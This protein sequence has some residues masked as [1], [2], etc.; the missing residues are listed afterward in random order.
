MSTRKF[1]P[2]SCTQ[3]LRGLVGTQ[4]SIEAVAAR[5]LWWKRHAKDFVKCWEHEFRRSD[6]TMRLNLIYVANDILQKSRE[7]GRFYVEEFFK[8]LPQA[9][10]HMMKHSDEAVQK[11]LKRLVNVWSDRKVFG[12]TAMKTFRTIVGDKAD[13]P[14]DAMPQQGLLQP[15]VDAAAARADVVKALTAA[16]AAK[17]SA[18]ESNQAAAPQIA[19]ALEQV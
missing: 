10:Q 4:A 19:T 17:A 2:A 8:Y 16:D 7:A 12:A 9:L 1:D 5:A 11:K 6:A 3:L 14:D 18:H 13:A 15:P